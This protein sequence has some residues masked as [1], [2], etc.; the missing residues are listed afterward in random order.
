MLSINYQTENIIVDHLPI[1]VCW[2]TNYPQKSFTIKVYKGAELVSLI[3]REGNKTIVTLD[4]I[5]LQSFTSYTIE[6]LTHGDNGENNVFKNSFTTSNLGHFSGR[7]VSGGHHFT[8]DIHYY[9]GKRNVVMRKTIYLDEELLDAYISIVG[10]GF[11]KLYINGKEVT[12]GEL[13]TD[14]TNYAKIIYYDT[15]NIKPFINQ[16]KNEVIVELADGWFNP[17]P[18]KLFGKYNLRETLTIG[19]PQVIADI[20]MKF[21]DREM[22]IGSD[23]DWQYCEGAYT[24]N[25]IYLGERLDM[26][27]FRGDN[28]TDL[29]MPDWKNVVLSNGPEGRLVSSFIPKINHT[30]SLGAEHIHVVDEETFIIDFGAIVTGFIDLS[31]TASENQR[32]ELL[33]SEDVDENYELNTDST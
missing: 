14:W 3:A 21:A 31:I 22:I 9:R 4:A 11:Y 26:K 13:N 5:S 10:L 12:R 25:N 18:L 15:Y 27:L 24:F 2:S 23:A 16:P 1:M 33:Y 29:L 20:Y 19:E 17:A 6:V 8:N 28:T 32:V 30:L 7:W